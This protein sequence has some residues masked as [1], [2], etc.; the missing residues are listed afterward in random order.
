MPVS[1]RARGSRAIVAA[2]CFAIVASAQ[3]LF[4]PAA[5]RASNDTPLAVGATAP[6]ISEPT[7]RGPF[8][9]AKSQRPY[10]L[11]FFALWCPHCQH[12]VEPLNELQRVDGSRV[13]IVAV[14]ASPFAFDKTSVLQ[15]TD[16]DLF[17]RRFH[18]HYRIGFDGLFFAAYD[19]GVAYFPTIYFVGVDRRVVAVET[20]EVPFEKLHADVEAMFVHP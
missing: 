7:D 16:V 15:Q 8:D 12:E 20:G 13:D 18:T 14:P 6:A 11:E 5:V 17:A 9:S 4:A 19:Y 10:V 2:T 1:R 3:W